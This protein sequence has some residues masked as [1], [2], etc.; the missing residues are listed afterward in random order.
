MKI[1][2]T[3][4]IEKDN[5]F[6]SY[7]HLTGLRNECKACS[8]LARQKYRHS[9]K[10]K[11][12]SIYASQKR[13][14]L[15]RGHTPPEYTL[16][17]LTDWLMLKGFKNLHLAWE[18]SNFD[19]NLAPSTDRLDNTKGYSF[20]NLRLVTFKDNYKASHITNKV[21]VLQLIGRTWIEHESATDAMHNTSIQQSGIVACCTGTKQVA[22]GYR[23]KYQNSNTK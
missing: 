7:S 4:K 5:A 10:G 1:C 6:F 23:W 2:N 17:E 22:G 21:K 19:A 12:N 11:I 9:E 16:K 18:K 15:T 3:C 20:D 13:A 14:S 8:K